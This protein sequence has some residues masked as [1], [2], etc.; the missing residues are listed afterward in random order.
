M[1]SK[2]SFV[3]ESKTN[4][5][6]KIIEDPVVKVNTLVTLNKP[7]KTIVKDIEQVNLNNN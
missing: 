4:S 5:C 1:L 2:G 3:R 6:G 7:E